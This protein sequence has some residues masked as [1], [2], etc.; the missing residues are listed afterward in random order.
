MVMCGW[1]GCSSGPCHPLS[2]L[3]ENIILEGADCYAREDGLEASV[4]WARDQEI[5]RVSW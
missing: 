2:M 3:L 1:Q 4:P 5:P